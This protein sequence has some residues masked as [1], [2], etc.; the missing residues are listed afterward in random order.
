MIGLGKTVLVVDSD[1]TVR[2]M[3]GDSLRGL[4]FER[5]VLTETI[6]QA[7]AALAPG[8]TVDLA[9]IDW[10]VGDQSGFDLAADIRTGRVP[11]RTDLPILMMAWKADPKSVL[12]AQGLKI[13]GLLV[14]PLSRD[15]LEKK[16]AGALAPPP[17]PEPKRALRQAS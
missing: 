15:T 12:A 4:R 11:P 7:K 14:K 5:V 9:L 10:Q 17:K 3:L 16:V 1:E 6:E 13:N 2:R 8:T